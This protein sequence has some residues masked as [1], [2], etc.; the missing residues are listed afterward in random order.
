MKIKEV[1]KEEKKRKTEEKKEKRLETEKQMV[2]M[3]FRYFI[4]I[5]QHRREKQE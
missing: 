2:Y 3:D 5:T 4:K 1:L